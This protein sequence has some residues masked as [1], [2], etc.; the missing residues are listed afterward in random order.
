MT[1]TILVW[2]GAT[3]LPKPAPPHD[4]QKI[5]NMLWMNLPVWQD[6]IGGGELGVKSIAILH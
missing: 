2:V 5:A 4:R 1:D 6:L 3:P